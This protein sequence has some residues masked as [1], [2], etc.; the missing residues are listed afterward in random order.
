MD[1]LI[2]L[3]VPFTLS[4]LLLQTDGRFWSTDGNQRNRDLNQASSRPD[5]CFLTINMQVTNRWAAREVRFPFTTPL[6]VAHAEILGKAIA[7]GLYSQGYSNIRHIA[8]TTLNCPAY[9]H[10]CLAHQIK[11][12]LLARDQE[13]QREGIVN[14]TMKHWRQPTT[15]AERQMQYIN[16]EEYGQICESAVLNH[17]TFA[18]FKSFP[19]YQRILEHT[20]VETGLWHLERIGQLA[21]LLLQDTAIADAMAKSAKVGY[22]PI[23][24]TYPTFGSNLISPSQLRYLAVVADIQR[25]VGT[26]LFSNGATIAEIGVGT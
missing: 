7:R 20:S 3:C 11:A 16:V 4:L 26:A 24:T 2:L 22:P 5:R 8:E 13:C 15:D 21:P 6:L 14:P 9:D 12:S 10:L 1:I 19:M 18:T 23:V 25:L 17:E